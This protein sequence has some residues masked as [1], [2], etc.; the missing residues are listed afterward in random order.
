MLMVTADLLIYIRNR[1]LERKAAQN[2][3]V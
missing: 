1:K 3:G 2:G